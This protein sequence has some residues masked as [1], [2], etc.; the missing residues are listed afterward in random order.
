MM[1]FSWL[2][3]KNF[4]IINYTIASDVYSE[5]DREKYV[6]FRSKNRQEYYILI[7]NGTKY[8]DYETLFM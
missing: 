3:S 1:R 5:S 2:N 4:N 8:N 7:N 6:F